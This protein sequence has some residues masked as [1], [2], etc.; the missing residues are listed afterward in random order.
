MYGATNFHDNS[1]HAA[2]NGM[3]PDRTGTQRVVRLKVDL[4][5]F[6]LLTVDAVSC[7]CLSEPASHTFK[8][9]EKLLKVE[10]V[11]FS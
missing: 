3:G 8:L 2:V 1:K 10:Q 4:L 7:C 9:V 11:E 5:F 6:I